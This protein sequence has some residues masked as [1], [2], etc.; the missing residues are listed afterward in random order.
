[1][2]G[3][4]GMWWLVG[5]LMAMWSWNVMCSFPCSPA[6]D[7]RC[8]D[9]CRSLVMAEVGVTEGAVDLSRSYT[10]VLRQ[11]GVASVSRSSLSCVY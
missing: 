2:V 10:L 7:S 11:E 9:C 1:V 8:V 3:N 6:L 5:Y 4:G